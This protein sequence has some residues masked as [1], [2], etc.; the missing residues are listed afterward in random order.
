MTLEGTTSRCAPFSF[1]EASLRTRAPA[2]TETNFSSGKTPAVVGERGPR[3]E[4][5]NEDGLVDSAG[6]GS[7]VFGRLSRLRRTLPD[8]FRYE[9]PCCRGCR[10]RT[11]TRGAS[12]LVFPPTVA[13]LRH[14]SSLPARLISRPVVTRFLSPSLFLFLYHRHE[15]VARNEK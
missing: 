8:P 5:M 11:A 6:P 3:E 2:T 15:Y 1:Q 10:A 12:S 13:R 14:R 7:L 9:P 4:T